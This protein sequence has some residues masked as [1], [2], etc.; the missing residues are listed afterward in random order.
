[1]SARARLILALFVL[2]ATAHA[3]AADAPPLVEDVPEQ[4]LR[5][6][7]TRVLQTLDLLGAPLAEPQR[8]MLDGAWGKPE[9]L[10]RA[11]AALDPLCVAV[12]SVNPESRVKVAE[13]PALKE[14]AQDG[15]RVFLVKVINEAGVTAKLRVQSPNAAPVYKPSS[16]RPDP[17]PAVKPEDIGDR[18]LDVMSYEKQPLNAAL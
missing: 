7:V 12:V 4:P 10:A 16:G 15:W 8:R 2:C 9:A 11:Q 13:G 17:P 5:A 1:M 3:R 14:L 18:W 6:Q